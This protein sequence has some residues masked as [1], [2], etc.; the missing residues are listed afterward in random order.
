MNENGTLRYL[1]EAYDSVRHSVEPIWAA[2][3][4]DVAMQAYLLLA[5]MALIAYGAVAISRTLRET[6]LAI[7][8]A[9][10]RF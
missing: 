4:S 3:N 6:A 7:R 8:G 9:V 1:G 5:A 2:L 10:R